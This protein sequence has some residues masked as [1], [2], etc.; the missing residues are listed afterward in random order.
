M[1]S[2]GIQGAPSNLTNTIDGIT[3]QYSN[4][5]HGHQS[6]AFANFSLP[7]KLGCRI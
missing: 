2:N 4:G 3:N 1:S 6:N 7:I 5:Q